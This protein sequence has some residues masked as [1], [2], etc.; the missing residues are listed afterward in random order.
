MSWLEETCHVEINLEILLVELLTCE[1][2]KPRRK[3]VLKLQPQTL[4]HL[5]KLYRM[6]VSED[7][8]IKVFFN[9]FLFTYSGLDMARYRS[10][11]TESV[12]SAE[13][14]LETFLFTF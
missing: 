4:K 14:I 9:L 13:P 7:E 3:T 8:I 1:L 12:K 6:E 11:V 10:I 5:G 2:K